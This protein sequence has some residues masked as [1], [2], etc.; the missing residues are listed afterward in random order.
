M[1]L[2]RIK[3]RTHDLLDPTTKDTYWDW[4][5]NIIIIV[6][7]LL[8]SIVVMLETVPSLHAKYNEGF[9]LFDL[10]SV[11]VFSVEYVLRVWSCTVEKKYR[12]PVWGRLRYIVSFG[13]IIDLLAIIPFY[14]HITS[15]ID[16]RELRLFRLLRFL[17]LLKL[18]R[19]LNASKVIS[20]VIKAKKEEFILCLGI[21]IFLIM[22]SS[23]LMY[24]AEHNAQPSKFSSIP[25]AMWWS[26]ITLTSVGY[27]DVYPIT[28]LGRLLASF[29]A[30]LGVGLFAL[31][32]G[33]FASAF[34]TEI[35][36][37]K[38]GT[39]FCPHC[40]KELHS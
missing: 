38:G 27:G 29:I 12:H 22:I 1:I 24:F 32:A 23:S 11:V 16:L 10:F 33:I 4:V 36:K 39:H 3:K 26:V 15:I 31:P 19:Y 35:N 14:I 37:T 40:G 13:A 7:I 6:L 8:N 34:L 20:N 18:G 17:R 28:S 5:V 21:I 30:I 25:S 2:N 9:R